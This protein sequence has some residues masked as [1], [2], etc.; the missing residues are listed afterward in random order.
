[1]TERVNIAR[2]AV[3]PRPTST[4][5]ARRSAVRNCLSSY[6]SSSRV[7][8]GISVTPSTAMT[9]SGSASAAVPTAGWAP[10]KVCRLSPPATSAASRPGR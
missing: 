6:S 1:M 3:S 8:A 7:P 5:S 4:R 2:M 9:T 10:R